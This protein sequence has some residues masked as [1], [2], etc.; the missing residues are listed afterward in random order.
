MYTFVHVQCLD[1]AVHMETQ[2][3]RA[4]LQVQ[5]VSAPALEPSAPPQPSKKGKAQREKARLKETFTQATGQIKP[6]KT[7][8]ICLF[9]YDISVI[10][11]EEK[12]V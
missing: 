9:R 5:A 12:R 6:Q 7:T 3:R 2:Q 10:Q 1:A 4:I 8:D 11:V